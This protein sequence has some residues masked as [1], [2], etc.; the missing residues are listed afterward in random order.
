[1]GRAPPRRR[2][3]VPS[4]V[5]HPLDPDGF[6]QATYRLTEAAGI[7]RWSPHAFRHSAATMLLAEG[8]DLKTISGTLGHSSLRVT[9][10]VYA[11]L[12]EPAKNEAADAIGR[13]LWGER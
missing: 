3:R 5:R 7:G 12:G 10:D 4:R 13:A 2:S 8:V 6:R 1:M 9:A 11:H